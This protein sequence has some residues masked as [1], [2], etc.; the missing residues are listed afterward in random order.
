MWKIDETIVCDQPSDINR[1]SEDLSQPLK[2]GHPKSSG[3]PVASVPFWMTF[4]A[5][6]VGFVSDLSGVGRSIY[7]PRW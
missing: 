4:L 6:N 7:V 1:C 2:E 5:I 3:T